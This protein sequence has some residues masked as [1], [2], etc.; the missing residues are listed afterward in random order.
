MEQVLREPTQKDALLDL[1]L[2]NRV[3]LVSEVGIGG[4]LG[5][6]VH[7]EIE[8]KMSVDR[9]KS[10]SKTS[11]LDMRREDF[12][13]FKELVSKVPLENVFAE[14]GVHQCWSLFKPPKSTGASN[15]QML[16]VKQ[17]RQ[18][19]GLAEQGSS[20]GNKAKKEAVCPVEARI[21]LDKLSS[22][23]LDKHTIRRNT[24]LKPNKKEQDVAG[25]GAMRRV[26]DSMGRCIRKW[27]DGHIQ[28]VVVNSSESQWTSVTS[29]V[30]QGSVLE[31]V[32][33]NIFI[34]DIDKGIKCT[35][36]KFVDDTKLSGAVDTP[37]GQDAI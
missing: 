33:F 18:K 11:T 15:S 30:P 37:E 21:L 7:K 2:V 12:R 16:E 32:F 22:P 6:S 1:M 25:E 31:P 13:L 24:Q 8:F 29:G 19:A 35:L 27:L 23:Q 5:H 20:L 28:R 36:S 9:R 3:D 4:R 17:V 26:M 34:N 10:A 14:A